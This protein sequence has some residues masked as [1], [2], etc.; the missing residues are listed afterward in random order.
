VHEYTLAAPA[1]IT[2]KC[3]NLERVPDAGPW[4]W[5]PMKLEG[6]VDGRA[7]SGAD[8]LMERPALLGNSREPCCD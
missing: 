6:E 8:P 5:C 3:R 4:S 2:W 1:C 7:H